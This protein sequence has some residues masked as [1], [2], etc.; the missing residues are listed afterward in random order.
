RGAPQGRGAFGYRA[1]QGGG[2]REPALRGSQLRPGDQSAHTLDAPAPCGIGL[3]ERPMS[4]SGEIMSRGD[5]A[6]RGATAAG[7][8]MKRLPYQ[9][10][11]SC[12][13]LSSV[14]GIHHPLSS[15]HLANSRRILTRVPLL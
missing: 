2:R 6:P 9:V 7:G 8:A 15:S 10:L 5:R 4:E 3:L 14:C 1:L 12:E 11:P 13:V